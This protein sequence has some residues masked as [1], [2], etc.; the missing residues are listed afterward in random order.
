MIDDNG[1]PLNVC[2]YAGTIDMFNSEKKFGLIKQTINPEISSRMFFHLNQVD[3]RDKSFVR[4]D[5]NV[6]FTFDDTEET[7]KPSAKKYG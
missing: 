1:D 7:G 4:K 3:S 5:A 2:T 6:V